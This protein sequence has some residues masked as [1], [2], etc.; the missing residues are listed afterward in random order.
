MASRSAWAPIQPSTY[1]THYNTWR[2]MDYVVRYGGLTPAQAL[3]A[4]TRSNARILGLDDVTG[5]IEP[6]KDADL[7]VLDGNPLDDF[8]AFTAPRMVVARGNH[9][10]ADRHPLRRRRR[11]AR[12]PL[13]RWAPVE[14][15][16]G[17]VAFAQH[18]EHPGHQFVDVRLG[19]VEHQIRVLRWLVRGIDA[20]E[21]LELTGSGARRRAP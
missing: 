7:V 12:H 16:L 9:R 5:S 18:L 14:G 19:R 15:P 6:G 11:G 17:P 8:R 3:H 1:V 4:A 20:G 21:A 13:T 10:T 2:E